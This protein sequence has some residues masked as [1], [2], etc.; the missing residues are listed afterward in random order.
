M[1]S[2]VIKPLCSFLLV[3]SS[4]LKYWP[5]IKGTFPPRSQHP[6]PHWQT[7]PSYDR[8]GWGL[9]S[10]PLS[11]TSRVALTNSFSRKL[12]L[13]WQFVVVL[14]KRLYSLQS[15]LFKLSSTNGELALYLVFYYG[16]CNKRQL[17]VIRCYS[18]RADPK[19]SPASKWNM[20]LF[21]MWRK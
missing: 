5:P 14:T 16:V 20:T 3:M 13:W 6:W 1:I 4:K 7:S 17:G 10:K 9:G 2:H 8:E 12:R 18:I 21:G 11:G 19:F 15:N